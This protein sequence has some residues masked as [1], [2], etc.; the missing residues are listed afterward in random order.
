[1]LVEQSQESEGEGIKTITQ[2]F[3]TLGQL[4]AYTDAEG[5][6]INEALSAKAYNRGDC[7]GGSGYLR[8]F[9]CP[10]ISAVACRVFCSWCSWRPNSSF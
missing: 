2:V 9:H 7:A 8:A 3:N 4:E 1:M 6:A 10:S 5:D